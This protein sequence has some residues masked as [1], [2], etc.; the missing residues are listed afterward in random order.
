MPPR[1]IDFSQ[2]NRTIQWLKNLK[3]GILACITAA[4]LS[5]G[6]A[7][8][9]ML[10]L[11]GPKSFKDNEA[12]LDYVESTTF[13]YFWDEANLT[14]G[15]IR[16]RS[17]SHSPCSVA[18]VGFGLSAINVG[19]ERGWIVRAEGRNRTLTTLRNPDPT[20]VTT[21]NSVVV[22]IILTEM[23]GPPRLAILPESIAAVLALPCG[24]A[25]AVS[26]GVQAGLERD[27]R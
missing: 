2:F 4:I 19:I 5:C 17:A 22:R 12:F 20:T 13:R 23:L 14:N 25:P 9:L 21:I 26:R 6:N 18:A 1:T 7:M 3:I 24:R 11:D 15:L 8:A 16:D 27:R 10:P